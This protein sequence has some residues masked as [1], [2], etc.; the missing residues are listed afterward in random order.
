MHKW[1]SFNDSERRSLT[2]IERFHGSRLGQSPVLRTTGRG[3][4]T[5]LKCDPYCQCWTVSTY[6]DLLVA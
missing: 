3:R 5:S 2:G 1:R 6:T 4:S